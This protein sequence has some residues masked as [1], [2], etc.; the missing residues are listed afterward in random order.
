MTKILCQNKTAKYLGA[1]LA[2][3][4]ILLDK[5]PDVRH[6]IG[7]NMI[8]LLRKD[9]LNATWSLQLGAWQ[10]AESEAAIHAVYEMFNEESTEVVFLVNVSNA[11]DSINLEPYLYNSNILCPYLSAYINKKLIFI[12][13]SLYSRLR[14]NKIRKTNNARWFY[15]NDNICTWNSISSYMAK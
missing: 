15:C 13:K 10:A 8:K 5:Q 3:R 9:V 7:K 6:I 2:C 12:N 14:V 4:L 11:F 1:F